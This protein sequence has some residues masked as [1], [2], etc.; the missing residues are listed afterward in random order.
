MKAASLEN[1]WEI[2][3][4]MALEKWLI[5]NSLIPVYDLQSWD[6][7]KQFQGQFDSKWMRSC[8]LLLYVYARKCITVTLQQG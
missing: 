3:L 8:A 4:L 6:D 7:F 5:K 2:F 1:T